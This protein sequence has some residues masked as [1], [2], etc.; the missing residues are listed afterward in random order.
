LPLVQKALTL[1][2]ELG[3]AY[4]AL[5]AIKFWKEWNFV[6]AEKA[7]KKGVKLDP[8]HGQC[9]NRYAEFLIKIGRATEAIPYRKKLVELD[10]ISPG[11]MR[12]LAEAYF[13]SGK[14]GEALAI[15]DELE[16]L[17]PDQ[18]SGEAGQIHLYLDSLEKAIVY[19]ENAVED[20]P[21][22]RF[23]GCLA[24]AYAKHGQDQKAQEVLERLIHIGQSKAGGSP[25]YFTA[26][27]YSGT[28]QNE[29][30]IEWLEKAYDSHDTE[31]TWL[32]ADPMFKSLHDDPGYQELLRRVGFPE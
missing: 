23:L 19:L 7:Y 1:N 6:E 30:A 26:L 21:I 27:Y 18:G 20:K 22:A 31:L 2:P 12:D 32:K 15:L 10:P 25:D 3:W 16:S 4:T 24:I 11:R 14:N 9:N 8:K 28:M 29:K 17:F 13:F 5:G